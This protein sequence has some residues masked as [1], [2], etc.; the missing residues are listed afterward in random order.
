MFQNDV[1]ERQVNEEETVGLPSPGLPM[2]LPWEL[3]WKGNWISVSGEGTHVSTSVDGGRCRGD[4]HVEGAPGGGEAIGTG[5]RWGSCED[6]KV[7]CQPT[8]LSRE[9]Q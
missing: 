5:R 6:R 4:S 7:T 8:G 2:S 9:E 3:E 1:W